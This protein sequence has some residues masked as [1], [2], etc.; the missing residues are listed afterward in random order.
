M[1]AMH[2][3]CPKALLLPLAIFLSACAT[4]PDIPAPTVL[5]PAIPQLV[6]T[7]QIVAPSQ[8]AWQW[9]EKRWFTAALDHGCYGVVRFVD[10]KNGIDSYIGKERV[11]NITFA[12]D[13]ADV[14]LAVVD[15]LYKQLIFSTDGGRHFVQEV[16]GLPKDQITKFVIVRSGHVYVGMELLGRNPDGYFQWQQP[17]FRNEW[18]SKPAA[19]ETHQL[20]ILEAPLDK[21]HG[22]I[23]SYMIL[24]PS[25]Y[26]FRS[27][28]AQEARSYIKRIDNIDAIGL[29]HAAVA[30]PSD[31]CGRTL[32]LP[33]WSPLMTKEGLLKFYDW[34]QTMKDTHPGW[35]TPETDDIIA[36]HRN[37]HRG[38]LIPGATTPSQGMQL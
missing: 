19:M 6:K 7:E 3:L 32:A 11:P 36:R 35:A 5:V 14:V 20:A 33:P 28:Q 10:E 30:A 2:Y 8:K 9:D 17:G 29:P 24:A 26:Q 34:Y 37:W 13:D 31:S 4:H 16:R 25:N 1:N 15:G 21:A 12:S 18:A 23:G 27:E 38:V 22:R